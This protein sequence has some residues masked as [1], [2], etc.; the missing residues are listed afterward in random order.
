MEETL[1]VSPGYLLIKGRMV[2]L[3][4]RQWVRQTRNGRENGVQLRPLIRV[5]AIQS[6]PS[7]GG[8]S[9]IFGRCPS[10]GLH[11]ERKDFRFMAAYS[12]SASRKASGQD[13]WWFCWYPALDTIL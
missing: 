11:G 10:N 2:P 9:G 12:P 1:S 5:I 8:I 4:T 7:I 6:I 13:Q 3:S